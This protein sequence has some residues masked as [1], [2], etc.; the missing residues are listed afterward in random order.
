ML[1]E[2][3]RGHYD[4]KRNN[5]G[6]TVVK[7]Y[8]AKAAHIISHCGIRWSAPEKIDVDCPS[9]VNEYNTDM[10]GVGIISH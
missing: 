4:F 5:E 3:G 8:D 9:V 1:K 7:W 10:G 2:S 6:I